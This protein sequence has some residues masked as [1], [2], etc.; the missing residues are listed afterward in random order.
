[1]WDFYQVNG[2]F[3]SVRDPRTLTAALTRLTYATSEL[4]AQV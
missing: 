2:A 4:W 1:M 3:Q